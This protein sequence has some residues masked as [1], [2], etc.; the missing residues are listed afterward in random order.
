MRPEH[1]R[2]ILALALASALASVFLGAACV[3][4]RERHE[5]WI[6]DSARA[7]ERTPG[8]AREALS[9]LDALNGSLAEPHEGDRAV[10]TDAMLERA[11][12]FAA[13]AVQQNPDEAPVLLARLGRLWT[14]AREPKKAER[15]YRD[16]VAA[17]PTLEGLGGLMGALG[18]RGAFDEVRAVC[19]DGAS[20]LADD[21][22]QEH[23]NACARA[24]H[25]TSGTQAEDWLKDADR[26]RWR[27]WVQKRQAAHAAEL[28]ER[29]ERAAEH[30]NR[31]RKLQVCR[32]TCD[33]KGAACKAQCQ[34]DQPRCAP[35]CEEMASAC[36]AKCEASVP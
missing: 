14:L 28:K 20:G 13:K 21:E 19:G 4:T 30:A 22:L 9:H 24:A 5:Q 29:E 11:E 32:A 6:Q 33:E 27:T 15:A 2:R 8:G 26:E 23:L 35:A 16:S 1:R 34:R 36:S 18:Q 12:G 7:M 17:R 10:V 25:A 3:S 31:E